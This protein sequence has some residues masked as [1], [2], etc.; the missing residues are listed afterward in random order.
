MKKRLFYSPWLF[1]IVFILTALIMTLY[2]TIKELIFKGSLTPW[3]S[4]TITILM[5]AAIATFTASLMHSW[6][7]SISLKE[8]E[9]NAKEQALASFE[10]TLTAVNHIVNN[11]LNYLQLVK[12]EVDNEGKIPEGTLKLLEESIAE[13]S[14]QMKILNRIQH[15]YDPESYK[16]IYPNNASK[17]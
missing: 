14:Q 1:F 2:E 5:T 16:A 6:V 13:S 7:L 9:V 4:H 15:P 8:K 17:T 10:L 12:I 11:V 3:Q